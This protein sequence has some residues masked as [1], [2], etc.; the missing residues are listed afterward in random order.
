MKQFLMLVGVAAVAGAMYVAGASGSQQTKF[1]P[2]SQVVALQKKVTSLSNQLKKTV[3]PEADFSVSY[4]LSCL[5]SVD[6]S[7]NI[8]IHT[9]PVSQR[10]NATSGYL[11]GS[12]SASSTPTTALDIN[13]STPAAQL[14]V[15]DP[16][17]LGSPLRHAAERAGYGSLA[18]VSMAKNTR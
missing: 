11:F 12:N 17:C 13:P 18:R 7:G 4:I 5:A 14:Q 3:K 9:M 15:F 10:G 1:A 2:E 16:S 8:T 6:T